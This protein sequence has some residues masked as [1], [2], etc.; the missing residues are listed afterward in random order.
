MLVFLKTVKTNLTK[1]RMP[2]KN[3]Y[4]EA[5]GGLTSSTYISRLYF[6]TNGKKPVR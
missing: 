3:G 5:L 6:L 1:V 2:L 4:K